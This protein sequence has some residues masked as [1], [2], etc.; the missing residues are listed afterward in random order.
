[1]M[2][3]DKKPFLI[4]KVRRV[5]NCLKLIYANLCGSI[6]IKLFGRS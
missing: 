3:Y 6:N 5:S 2:H 1:M 4:E